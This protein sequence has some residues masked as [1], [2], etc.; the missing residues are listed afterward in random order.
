MTIA[1]L[2]ITLAAAAFTRVEIK[3][4]SEAMN[5]DIPVIVALPDGYQT[6]NALRTVYLLHGY[7]GQ[8]HGME[9]EGQRLPPWPTP[10]A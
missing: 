10:T 1:A 6:M 3:V 4:H 7:R 9:R 8:L 2:F 5:K